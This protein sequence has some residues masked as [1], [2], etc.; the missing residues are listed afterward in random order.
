MSERPKDIVKDVNK[1]TESIVDMKAEFYVLK[2]FVMEEIYNINIRL[3]CV[4]AEC[5]HMESKNDMGAKL[6]TKSEIIKAEK[7][8]NTANLS[9]ARHK[10]NSNQNLTDHFQSRITKVYFPENIPFSTKTL[11][12]LLMSVFFSKKSAFYVKNST[13]TQSKG[14]GALFK[15]F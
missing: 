7:F 10:T 15:I 5:D 4:R 9:Y 11:L 13:F 8:S 14:M 3:D 1:F 6:Q 2:W 12:I